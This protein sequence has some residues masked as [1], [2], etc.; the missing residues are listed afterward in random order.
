MMFT[1]YRYFVNYM[2]RHSPSCSYAAIDAGVAEIVAALKNNNNMYKN[3]YIIF[4]SDNGGTNSA[5]SSTYPLRGH[6]GSY[7]EGGK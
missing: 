2:P 3:S 1:F 7:F 5:G 6:K 4:T